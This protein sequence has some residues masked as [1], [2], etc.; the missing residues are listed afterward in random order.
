MLRVFTL[1]IA[2]LIS[3]PASLAEDPSAADR[4]AFQRIIGEQIEAFRADDGARAYGYAA[5]MIRQIFPTPEQ[6]MAMVKQGL[7]DGLPPAVLPLRRGR[8]RFGR[9]AHPARRHHR[10]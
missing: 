4:Q 3:I 1:L 8:T 2:I 5:P 7:P 9:Q 10:S 6:F